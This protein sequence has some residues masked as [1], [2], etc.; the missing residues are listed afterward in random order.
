V[1]IKGRLR[2]GQSCKPFSCADEF[3]LSLK[4]REEREERRKAKGREIL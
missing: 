4:E 1:V 3:L 2:G